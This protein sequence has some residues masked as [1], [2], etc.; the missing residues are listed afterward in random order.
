MKF[1]LFVLAIVALV[2]LPVHSEVLTVDD[3]AF[4]GTRAPVLGDTPCGVTI[5]CGMG[6][7]SDCATVAGCVAEYH[8]TGLNNRIFRDGVASQCDPNKPC[9]GNFGA[10]GMVADTFQFDTDEADEG[11]V[12]RCLEVQWN[13]GTCG[14]TIHGIANDG[15]WMGGGTTYACTGTGP[16]G[17]PFNYVGD[18]GSSVTQSFF[19]PF[20][21]IGDMFSV[22]G[23]Q[24]FAGSIGC[25]YSFTVECASSAGL[26]CTILPVLDAIEFKL[27][28]FECG[29]GPSTMAPSRL[30]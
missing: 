18:V 20:E 7:T 10:T 19:A 27:D 9:P 25:S 24:N 17:N 4:G 30:R 2:A 3:T 22:T 8:Q 29:S 12:C 15:I 26:E 5:N 28:N 14:A 21:L 1:N 11:N 23:H 6:T 13:V 16:D